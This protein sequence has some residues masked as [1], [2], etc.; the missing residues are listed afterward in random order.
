MTLYNAYLHFLKAQEEISDKYQRIIDR[1]GRK[2]PS[3]MD[4]I[5]L[6]LQRDARVYFFL[7][8]AKTHPLTVHDIVK[9]LSEKQ[10]KHWSCT[11]NLTKGAPEHVMEALKEAT[12]DPDP[13]FALL[14]K[15][16]YYDIKNDTCLDIA[17]SVKGEPLADG[18]EITYSV[19]Y[20]LTTRAPY[21]Y[22]RQDH[23]VLDNMNF[24]SIFTGGV[25]NN[26]V[27]WLPFPNEESTNFMNGVVIDYMKSVKIAQNNNRK[28]FDK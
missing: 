14:A 22:V 26:R 25:F 20:T 4:K 16:T 10:G 28:N 21:E 3:L 23:D 19:P 6:D 18:T 1:T 24:Y 11:A 12:R 2:D 5:S 9:H 15:Q 8:Y 13:T 27:M 7:E 17:F